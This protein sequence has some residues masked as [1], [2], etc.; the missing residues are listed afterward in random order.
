MTPEEQQTARRRMQ[1]LR[2]LSLHAG[3]TAMPAKLRDEMEETGFPMTL[4]K[5][6]LD[7]AFLAELEL[8]SAPEA[9]KIT[10]TADGLDV[11]RGLVKLPGL[12]TPPTVV[13]A[14]SDSPVRASQGGDPAAGTPPAVAQEL[15]DVWRG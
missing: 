9:G 14:S 7:C 8:V 11:V 1:V 10:L 15:S 12:G 3:H 6:M 2:A 5:L 4:T 13:S